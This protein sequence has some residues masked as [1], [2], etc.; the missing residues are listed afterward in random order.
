MKDPP[1]KWH[2]TAIPVGWLER[3]Y[4][5]ATLHTNPEVQFV[6]F[7]ITRRTTTEKPVVELLKQKKTLD[8]LFKK[9]DKEWRKWLDANWHLYKNRFVREMLKSALELDIHE[10]AIDADGRQIGREKLKILL[11]RFTK[12]TLPTNK[13]K[14]RRD[15]LAVLRRLR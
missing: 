9:A 13:K 8:P 2:L 14:A 3:K 11:K 6:R 12:A 10:G 5:A 4:S 1:A 7:R 15:P